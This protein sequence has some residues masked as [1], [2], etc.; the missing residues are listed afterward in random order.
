MP[1]FDQLEEVFKLVQRTGDRCIILSREHDPFVIMDLGT[2]Q[3]LLE[4]AASLTK[5]STMTEEELLG[6]LNRQIGE[7]KQSHRELD[8]YDLSQFQVDT[9]RRGVETGGR[10]ARARKAPTADV[11]NLPI[12]EEESVPLPSSDQADEYHLEPLG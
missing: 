2:Y 6:H 3:R 12:I 8:D 9:I 5:L 7:W 4:S 11:E 1:S 10:T